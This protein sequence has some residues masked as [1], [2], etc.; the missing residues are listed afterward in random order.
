MGT[1]EFLVV[2]LLE[3]FQRDMIWR[4]DSRILQSTSLLVDWQVVLCSELLGYHHRSAGC[5]TLCQS[6]PSHWF[7]LQSR[8]CKLQKNNGASQ[9]TFAK[10]TDPTLGTKCVLY[11][12]TKR[13]ETVTTDLGVYGLSGN[14]FCSCSPLSHTVYF[15]SRNLSR[16]KT[17]SCISA[18]RDWYSFL[19]YQ[20]V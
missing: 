20:Q 2:C 8:T 6:Y 12:T 18:K 5:W 11:S 13:L 9:A 17:A 19:K 1:L 14:F 7:R 15:A 16:G 3:F 4:V 10:E